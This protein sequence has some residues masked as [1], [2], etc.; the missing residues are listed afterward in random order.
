MLMT[1]C[2]YPYKNA[3][4]EIR[5]QIRLQTLFPH[6]CTTLHTFVFSLI[7]VL[8]LRKVEQWISK[9]FANEAAEPANEVA[10]G[11]QKIFLKGC[12]GGFCSYAS[13]Y[14]SKIHLK[15]AIFVMVHVKRNIFYSTCI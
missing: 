5:L 12:E 1:H 9:S 8:N 6:S 14:F 3:I 13:P 15:V 10:Q 11:L 4:V 7:K 2:S